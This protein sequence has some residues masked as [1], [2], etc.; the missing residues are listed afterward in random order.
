MARLPLHVPRTEGQPEATARGAQGGA[1]LGIRAG[2]DCI[3]CHC[4]VSKAPSFAKIGAFRNEL[5]PETVQYK[6]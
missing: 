1:I 2:E 5:T 6:N 4:H 3:D